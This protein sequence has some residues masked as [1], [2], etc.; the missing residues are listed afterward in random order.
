MMYFIKIVD[1]H[2]AKISAIRYKIDNHY[3][4]AADIQ[5]ELSGLHNIHYANCEN[6]KSEDSKL[7]R[8][9]CFNIL[10]IIYLHI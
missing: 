5:E 4:E 10:F 2:N 9:K 8:N 7:L 1:N 3:Y 6:S